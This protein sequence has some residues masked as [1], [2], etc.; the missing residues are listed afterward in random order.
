MG[1]RRAGRQGQPGD[2]R[3]VQA[4]GIGSCERRRALVGKDR[5]GSGVPGRALLEGQVVIELVLPYPVSANRYWRTF[6]IRGQTRAVT[7][8]SEE[9][10]TFKRE[11]AA[12]AL[13]AGICRPV[14]G[15]V[16]L[17]ITLFP[18][19]PK[20]AAKRMRADPLSWDD[21]V[22]SI[23]LDNAL[24]VLID[25]IKGCVIADDRW[26][27]QLIARRA[28]PDGQARAVVRVEQLVTVS[29]QASL[30]EE[31]ATCSAP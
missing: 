29:P 8:L 12:R 25:A 26:V 19:M 16:A 3:H 20:D 13:E 6:V 11:V 31:F 2:E 4:P 28:E 21:T 15:R 14:D 17:E 30:I 18:G 22:R 9:A 10:K 1:N 7:A 27:W 23:D 24:K 5:A